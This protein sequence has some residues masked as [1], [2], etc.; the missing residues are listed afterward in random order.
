[1]TTN[2]LQPASCLLVIIMLVT[3]TGLAVADGS[4]TQARNL[5]LSQQTDLMGTSSWA[6]DGTFEPI[7]SVTKAPECTT[8]CTC[9][10]IYG[11][12]HCCSLCCDCLGLPDGACDIAA[13]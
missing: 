1:M 4:D 8:P 11:Y 7:K 6:D 2:R 13:E 5:T 9:C 10:Y 3:A 12:P